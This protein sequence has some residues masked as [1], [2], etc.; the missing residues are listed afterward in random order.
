MA[1]P[2]CVQHKQILKSNN[3]YNNDKNDG[4]SLNLKSSGDKNTS[5]DI[6]IYIY[7]INTN[8]TKTLVLLLFI[9]YR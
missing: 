9:N 5:D 6:S 8:L 7:N 4:T 3:G 1:T 2:V